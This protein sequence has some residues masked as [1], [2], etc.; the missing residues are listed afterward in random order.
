[1]FSAERAPAIAGIYWVLV[2]AVF[3]FSQRLGLNMTGHGS[4]P[5]ILLTMPW[6]LFALLTWQLVELLPYGAEM[7]RPLNTA[8]GMCVMFPVMCGGLNAILILATASAV[9]RRQRRR[10]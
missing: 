6:S 7:L 2:L 8:L 4:V 5:V 1:M 10:R 3:F 9:Q